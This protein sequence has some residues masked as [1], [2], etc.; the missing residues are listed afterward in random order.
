MPLPDRELV[1]K[2]MPRQATPEENLLV[3]ILYQAEIDMQNAHGVLQGLDL[4]L[5]DS[6]AIAWR[7]LGAAALHDE[8][9]RYFT[10]PLSSL[11]PIC[12]VIG[13]DVGAVRAAVREHLFTEPGA[14]AVALHAHRWLRQRGHLDDMRS[15]GGSRRDI[16]KQA[17]EQWPHDLR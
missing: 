12:T 2:R 15:A 5:I 7:V 16:L 8:A 13:L 17:R 10:D 1:L 9:A 6:P 3:A 4:D 14:K 11:V